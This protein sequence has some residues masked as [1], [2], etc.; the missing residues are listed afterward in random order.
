MCVRATG[1]PKLAFLTHQSRGPS[2][3]ISLFHGNST[4]GF[5][6]STECNSR[7][8]V[9]S[10]VGFCCHVL[11]RHSTLGSMFL[12]GRDSSPFPLLTCM[13]LA[14][15]LLVLLVGGVNCERDGGGKRENWLQRSDV[16]NQKKPVR[17]IGLVASAPPKGRESAS[18]WKVR[19][20]QV[21][22]SNRK[23]AWKVPWVD[24]VLSA[25]AWSTRSL[26][27]LRPCC[28]VKLRGCENTRFDRCLPV[29]ST[30][31]TPTWARSY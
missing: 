23:A 20:W 22:L 3:R 18:A 28:P 15:L 13:F 7:A 29:C 9:Y 27:L 24:V 6:S 8:P 4:R 17:E 14:L 31:L 16:G 12:P 19:R 30:V 25:V 10:T 5:C 26:S 1:H 2:A 21:L 11:L